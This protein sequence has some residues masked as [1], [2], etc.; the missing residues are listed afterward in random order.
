MIRCK[1]GEAT[2]YQYEADDG[3]ASTPGRRPGNV[4]G[5]PVGRPGGGTAIS[6]GNHLA[7]RLSSFEQLAMRARSVN[8]GLAVG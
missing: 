7:P 1:P 3:G 5:E 6:L 2:P 8:A 4:G